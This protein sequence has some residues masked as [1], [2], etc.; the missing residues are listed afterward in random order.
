MSPIAVTEWLFPVVLVV[1]VIGLIGIALPIIPG[2]LLI[3][4]AG[5]VYAIAERFATFDPI[6]FVVFTVL[7]AFGMASEFLLTQAGAKAGGASTRAMLGGAVGGVVGLI[8]GFFVGGIGA[9]PGGLIGALVGVT[10]VE[11][12]QHRNLAKAGKA[13]GGWVAG[14]LASKLVEFLIAFTMIAIFI[15]QAGLRVN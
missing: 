4:V 14:C 10:L 5:L 15:W 6:S 8:V 7:G 11:Y 12:L 9:V 13:A 3:W 1:M 2:I